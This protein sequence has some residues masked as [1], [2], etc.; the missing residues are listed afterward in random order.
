MSPSGSSFP[1]LSFNSLGIKKT[2]SVDRKHRLLIA[3]YL[4]ISGHDLS[5]WLDPTDKT[6]YKSVLAGI[7]LHN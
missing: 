6:L 7:L 2:P 5:S 1:K 3:L 4:N